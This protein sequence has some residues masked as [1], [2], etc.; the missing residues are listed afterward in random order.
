MKRLL[1]LLFIA[2]TALGA[3]ELRL[4]LE[5]KS[6]TATWRTY[7]QVIDGVEVLGT[8]VVQRVDN[9]GS[10]HEVVRDIAHLHGGQ[11]LLPVPR[12]DRQE[13]L[14]STETC[15]YVNVGGE[16]R[17]M[18][19][20]HGSVIWN[21]KARVFDPNPVAKLND[22]SLRD[23]NNA[24]GAVPESVYS[25]VE[26]PDL[27]PSGML[28]GP[29]VRIVDTD[30]PFT[31]HADASQPLLFDRSQPQFEEVNA[32][33]HIDASQRYLQSLGYTGE[34][35]VVAYAIP[36]DAHALGGSDN[37]FYAGGNADGQGQ[38]YF[39][40]G[41]TDDAE[42]SD[43]VMHEYAHAIQDWIAPG[44]FGGAL[45]SQS[46]AMAEGFGFYWAF[47]T[48]Y[49]QT[50]ASG[51]DPFCIADWDARCFGDDSGQ[52]CGY[53]D[54]ADC[55]RRVDSPKTMPDYVTAELPGTEH[56]N[57]EIWA[58]AL[59][60]IFLAFVKQHGVEQG[61]RM[62]DS[63]VVEG[64]FGVPPS[65]TFNVMARKLLEADRALWGGQHGAA[66]CAA[67]TSRGI[68]A[69]GECGVMPRGELT[70]I[71][72]GARG[73]ALPATASV[74]V[75]DARPVDK[76]LVR[77]DVETPSRGAL[78]ITLTAPDGTTRTLLAPS[79]DKV[80]DV[81]A[82]FDVDVNGKPIAGTWTLTVSGGTGRLLDFALIAKFSGDEPLAT[83]PNASQRQIIPVIAHTTGVGGT[84]WRSDL[85][86]FGRGLVTLVYTPSG[87]DGT[88]T[89]GAVNVIVPPGQVVA[90]RDVV[91]QLFGQGGSGT[92]EIQGG[93]Q[94]W[95]ATYDAVARIGQSIEPV[96]AGDA[97]P[98][99]LYV[100][101]AANHGGRTN[102]GIV[103]TAG[104]SGT[105]TVT[106]GFFYSRTVPLLPFTHVQFTLPPI[107]LAVPSPVE[108]LTSGGAR[109]VAY[110][111]TVGSDAIYIPG[112]GLAG[113]HMEVIPVAAFAPGAFGA[114]W[115]TDL[116]VERAFSSSDSA[117][118]SVR[119][120]SS[121]FTVPPSGRT[122]FE[123]VVATLTGSTPSAGQ[124]ELNLPPDV[125]GATF[126]YSAPARRGDT[127]LAAAPLAVA[128]DAMPVENDAAFRTNVGISEVA[129]APVTVR[130]TV[131]DAA[132]NALSSRDF[133]VPARGLVQ[134]GLGVPVVDG[135]VHFEV[136][137]GSGKIVGYASIVD[138]ASQDAYFV[139]AR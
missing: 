136:I 10:V 66:I 45:A 11:A 14:S 129:G 56:A 23:H 1:L 80:A 97:G 43:V 113:A 60:E 112:R 131:F 114:T 71:E 74:T 103:E 58:S 77:V 121:G 139:R 122:Y 110:A 55:L 87:A 2:Q 52:Q 63:A 125:F 96:R 107:A 134:A 42:D 90:F 83:R 9:D 27:A 104:V 46:R 49:A 53:P 88:T 7:R 116:W 3:E 18:P 101:T 17:L 28:S 85:F 22:P 38:I 73:A 93:V 48:S 72:S 62:I 137:A 6:L 92:L 39:G 41:G 24:A 84:A 36:V 70:V 20:P 50:A 118:A 109:I 30:P 65:P 138:N 99:P 123:N 69:A 78:Q 21:A 124:L 25:I 31:E 115:Q 98:G 64:T 79:L 12:E 59:R 102:I 130:V 106:S 76:L 126:L 26:L 32:Y 119:Y 120:G 132:G 16:A 68:L 44:A 86:L 100:Q 13:C 82:T 37:S 128:G 29:N 135:R 61:K 95:S 111:S 105:A 94:V 47:S 133:D 15:V 19:R 33:F 51:R 89:F 67:M 4:V 108:V 54:G 35:R 91:E 57:G 5:R 81:H 117:L 75:N 127:I 34:R 8:A 40:D